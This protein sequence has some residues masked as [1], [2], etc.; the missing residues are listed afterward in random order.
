MYK[1][2]K[3]L[4]YWTCP[5]FIVATLSGC[6]G[7]PADTTTNQPSSLNNKP[8]ANSSIDSSVENSIAPPLSSSSS[9]SSNRLSSAASLPKSS[10]DS[11]TRVSKASSSLSSTSSQGA[12]Q[13]TDIT[14]P[15]A[16]NLLL[17]KLSG[18]SITL[19]WDH[20]TDNTEVISYEIERNG[21][22]ITA[23]EFPTYS[24]S[25]K[26]LNPYTDYV[27]TIRSFDLAGNPSAKSPLFKVR[28]LATTNSSSNS[29]SST[30]SSS[31]NIQTT[32]TLSWLHPDKRENG[33]FLEL[34]EIGGYELRFKETTSTT[35]T[36]LTL[37]GNMTNSYTTN[38]IPADGDI[39]I[40]VFDTNGL[41]S[42]FIPIHPQ[43]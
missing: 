12:I 30:N 4:V 2:V 37:H 6:G 41:Y 5:L 14:P 16:T 34:D 22:I 40:A 7:A 38:L 27:Y 20:A 31:S 29:K 43:K 15:T 36:H 18:N 11:Y 42:D 21:A 8:N 10:V 25:D 13:E 17:H 32:T 26:N 28:T 1:C 19:K 9:V 39:Q 35:Y 24:F 33:Q 23:I 3:K